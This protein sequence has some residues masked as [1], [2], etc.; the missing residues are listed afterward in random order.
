[1]SYDVSTN[2]TQSIGQAVPLQGRIK[3]S[4]NIKLFTEKELQNILLSIDNLMSVFAY[5]K[6]PYMRRD[7][8]CLSLRDDNLFG[9]RKLPNLYDTKVFTGSGKS[10]LKASIKDIKY[11]NLDKIMA[12]PENAE[13]IEKLKIFYTMNFPAVIECFLYQKTGFFANP[14]R[15]KETGYYSEHQTIMTVGTEGELEDMPT[16]GNMLELL[17]QDGLVNP[18]IAIRMFLMPSSHL[19]LIMDI[20]IR[21]E[22]TNQVSAKDF[23]KLTKLA[24]QKFYGSY[25]INLL[26]QRLSELLNNSAY[27]NNNIISQL[28]ELTPEGNLKNLNNGEIIL[29]LFEMIFIFLR[30]KFIDY[31]LQL[32]DVEVKETEKPLVAIEDIA[33]V[34][35]KYKSDALGI[36]DNISDIITLHDNPIINLLYSESIDRTSNTSLF[37]NP[38]IITN[39]NSLL[40]LV[41]AF[42]QK[43]VEP[44]EVKDLEKGG[45]V[46]LQY[47]EGYLA[48]LLGIRI[49]KIAHVLKHQSISNV[50][51]YR[52]FF[53]KDIPENMD[54][55]LTNATALRNSIQ[56][57]IP[58]DI[59]I[60][61]KIYDRIKI[62]INRLKQLNNEWSSYFHY[63]I[64]LLGY[65][66][67][68][69][70]FLIIYENT[71]EDDT[72]TTNIFNH[73][74]ILSDI[75]QI[76][77]K[78]FE[79]TPDKSIMTKLR[80]LPYKLTDE[81]EIIAN[82]I[83]Q[84]YKRI[85]SKLTT[86]VSFEVIHSLKPAESYKN[87]PI[88]VQYPVSIYNIAVRTTYFMFNKIIELINTTDARINY[89]KIMQICDSIEINFSEITQI[90]DKSRSS[91]S[92]STKPHKKDA[93]YLENHEILTKMSRL[94]WAI[95]NI[96]NRADASYNYVNPA[97]PATPPVDKIKLTELFGNIIS[98][99]AKLNNKLYVGVDEI[100]YYMIKPVNLVVNLMYYITNVFT[101]NTTLLLPEL[102]MA[103]EIKPG[104]DK[105]SLYN[106]YTEFNNNWLGG[107]EHFY[108]AIYN[109]RNGTDEYR[110]LKADINSNIISN[111]KFGTIYTNSLDLI[112]SNNNDINNLKINQLFISANNLI[113]DQITNITNP[114]NSTIYNDF[115]LETVSD[116][117]KNDDTICKLIRNFQAN[118]DCSDPQNA[119]RLQYD[120]KYKPS[121][122]NNYVGEYNII[123]G[124]HTLYE[125][126]TSQNT[127]NAMVYLYLD[128][129]DYY[130]N[131]HDEIIRLLTDKTATINN[132]IA[133]SNINGVA[134]QLFCDGFEKMLFKFT[135][136]EGRNANTY[137]FKGFC[138]TIRTIF[139]DDD[140][141]QLGNYL[142]YGDDNGGYIDYPRTGDIAS[143]SGDIPTILGTSYYDPGGAE[144]ILDNNFLA[145]LKRLSCISRFYDGSENDNLINNF[146]I[147]AGAGNEVIGY[148]EW[149]ANKNYYKF[150]VQ[151]F[152]ENYFENGINNYINTSFLRDYF[153]KVIYQNCALEQNNLLTKEDKIKL[154]ITSIYTL[155]YLLNNGIAGFDVEKYLEF[156]FIILGI[157][158]LGE[159]SLDNIL[160]S[161]YFSISHII[162]NETN[163]IDAFTNKFFKN[164]IS[165]YCKVNDDIVNLNNQLVINYVKS[166]SIYKA[167]LLASKVI[168]DNTLNGNTY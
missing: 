109:V 150:S 134:P 163:W 71:T 59:D 30:M 88:R 94:I 122:L 139:Q 154:I 108:K 143:I 37:L 148:K 119:N 60:A 36:Y 159:S 16:Y 10:L 141:E 112:N 4:E 17:K 73:D 8:G 86:N 55:L 162:N 98:S 9:N 115:L 138:D 114:A 81:I 85:E 5:G 58:S 22:L 121:I 51:E 136:I 76:R 62:I 84:I 42:K 49:D 1:M 99:I 61:T 31:Q 33:K 156:G 80:S 161:T 168:N 70:E 144:R 92:S 130:K 128:V 35:S 57:G 146:I 50:S 39:N 107:N 129:L 14:S 6:V 93:I 40:E 160:P 110:K 83:Q 118:D 43:A 116:L 63:F 72:N 158:A 127:N 102:V 111:R 165:Y 20:D 67:H 103:D 11:K 29:D 12:I 155:S 54:D 164:H 106:K 24:L 145:V 87:N 56:T 69:I 47:Y 142:L 79:D 45:L 75:N 104:A 15:A 100:N 34:S 44:K 105:K 38:K 82:Q 125:N 32:Y 3:T 65:Y 89:E 2:A 64:A 90:Y 68:A 126:L 97:A 101:K 77:K 27:E 140:D 149:N 7:L 135:D 132:A 157:S 137:D 13:G 166:L 26:E 23:K 25:A 96:L 147:V 95:C 113:T 123:P 124:R 28:L 120:I 52:D 48:Y 131:N 19:K 133:A 41:K 74:A 152:K 66:Y 91:T 78:I 167:N 46:G 21:N 18:D 151:Y 153:I 53:K 117:Q